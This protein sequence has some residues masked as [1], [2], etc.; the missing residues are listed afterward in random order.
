[1]VFT[2]TKH[3]EQRRQQR[4]FKLSYINLILKYGKMKYKPGN[5]FE[6]KIFKKDIEYIIQKSKRIIQ[7]LDKCCKKAILVDETHNKIITMYNLYPR[8]G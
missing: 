8:K 3:A 2:I 5:C 7:D 4:G 1:M 6:Y